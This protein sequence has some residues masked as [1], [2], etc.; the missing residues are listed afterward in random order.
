MQIDKAKAMLEKLEADSLIQNFIAQS[1]SR[2]ILFNVQ[3]PIDNFPKY[4]QGLDEKLTSTAMSYLS[5][6]CSCAEQGYIGESIFPLEKGATILENI[7]SPRAN[8]N[9][10]SSYFVLASSLA[11]YAANQYSKSY[12][13]LK[14]ISVDT[15]IGEVISKFL[16]R[17]Y[18]ELDKS[19]SEILLS[20]DYVDKTIATLDDET[21][22]IIVYI[23]SFYPSLLPVF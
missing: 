14:H 9:N 15:V 21:V 22:L 17:Q 3:E 18:T 12:I 5:V 20:N 19:L 8:R 4:S 1:D 7:Y 16:R 13:L 2:F 11:F 6:G 23:F 10:Y